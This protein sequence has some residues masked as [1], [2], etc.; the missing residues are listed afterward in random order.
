M[1]LKTVTRFKI[2][3]F[4]ETIK[5]HI[6]D[7][8]IHRLPVTFKIHIEDNKNTTLWGNQ[9]TYCRKV[10]E[11]SS[12]VMWATLYTVSLRI[13]KHILCEQNTPFPLET[14]ITHLWKLNTSALSKVQNTYCWCVKNPSK[15]NVHV[16]WCVKEPSRWENQ[17]HIVGN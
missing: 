15:Y 3:V 6:I 9:H 7:N 2:P 14:K 5:R 16:L 11:P 1:S 10:K 4:P 17:M 8:L 13:S 12:W